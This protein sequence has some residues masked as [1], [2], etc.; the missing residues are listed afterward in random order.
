METTITSHW[1]ELRP[2]PQAHCPQTDQKNKNSLFDE[3]HSNLSNLDNNTSLC[4]NLY[5]TVIRNYSGNGT[6]NT[7]GIPCEERYY[8][9]NGSAI[10]TWCKAGY[11][12]PGG[13]EPQPCSA[14]HYCPSGNTNY[15][16]IITLMF[17]PFFEGILS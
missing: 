11:Y 6:V 13:I 14:G 10:P 17:Y 2:R 4:S 1:R 15:H 9:P 16:L 8:C 3:V 5:V 12:C 7:H